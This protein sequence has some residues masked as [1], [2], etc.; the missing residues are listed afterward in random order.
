MVRAEETVRCARCG[1][2]VARRVQ[3]VKKDGD[4]GYLSHSTELLC[5]ACDEVECFIEGCEA[6]AASVLDHR[7]ML[8]DILGDDN[9]P[10]EFDNDLCLCGKHATQVRRI[11]RLVRPAIAMGLAAGIC[12]L[13]ALSGLVH[14]FF[15]PIH[16]PFAIAGGV[17]L[18][19]TVVLGWFA[20]AAERT[21]HLVKKRRWM[22]EIGSDK[23]D[24]LL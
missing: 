9:E 7:F 23:D 14:G 6:R 15:V 2:K 19:A 4:G 17:F 12:L 5:P 8:C 16:L 11:Q 24:S 1:G 22:T 20:K 21:S 3:D 18:L 13:V 10:L